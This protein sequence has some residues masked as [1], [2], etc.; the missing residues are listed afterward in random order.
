MADDG[1][2]PEDSSKTEDPTPKKL[3]E[4]RK[5]GQVPQSREINT[6]I[7]LLG[8]T[9][10]IGI[11]TPSLFSNF[12]IFLRSYFEQAHQM[13][14]MQGGISL[15][16]SETF[17]HSLGFIAIPLLVLMFSAFIGP[18]MQ[19][20]FLIAPEVLKFD[21][22]K[23]SPIKGWQRLFSMRSVVEFIKGVLKITVIGVVSFVMVY[24]YMPGVEHT[25]G[26]PFG[27]LLHEMKDLTIRLLS[28]ILVILLIV[29]IAD[30]LY[31][32][33]EFMK[34]MR[35]TKQELKDEYKQ[36][37]GDPYIKGRLKQ[38]RVERARKRM[39]QQVPKADVVI[40]NP[41][42][43]AVALQYNPEEMDAPMVIAKG[44]DNVALKIR[45]VAKEHGVELYENKPLAR[46]LFDTV[47]VDQPIPP[48]L[49]KAVAEII[50][51]VFK[52]KGKLKAKPAAPR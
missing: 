16:L 26:Q 39:M 33:W 41:T 36:T 51:F 30:L 37:E 38:L 4:S 46:T 24:P 11:A 49:Y 35:M 48:D 6:W 34:K 23:V 8:A 32:R 5:R 27:D 20:G 2:Q 9:L 14:G 10:V 42:H 28:G 18:F 19:F 47:D 31:Q 7:T 22:G 3:E 15:V 17:W 52:K 40:T 29:A 13:P 50:S 45:E 44:A 12:T 25:I 1:E 43:F 21:L